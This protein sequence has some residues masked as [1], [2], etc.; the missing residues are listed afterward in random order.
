MPYIE[1]S[2]ELTKAA[3]NLGVGVLNLGK[4]A[5]KAAGAFERA[6]EVFER[7]HPKKTLGKCQECETVTIL[8]ETSWGDRI[9]EGCWSDVTNG[10][11]LPEKAIG[12]K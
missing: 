2:H 3:E 12:E 1:L 9:C 11:P 4:A 10:A 8:F 7:M 6:I 5:L